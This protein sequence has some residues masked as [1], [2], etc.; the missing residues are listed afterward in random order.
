MQD[1]ELRGPYSGPGS[2]TDY[3]GDLAQVAL[4]KETSK[5]LSAYCSH[6]YKVLYIHI[7]TATELNK[8]LYL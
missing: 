2:A 5:M 7:I 3:L 1:S 4:L 8:R 6:E